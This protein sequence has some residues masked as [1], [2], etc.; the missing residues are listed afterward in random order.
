MSVIKYTTKPMAAIL[1]LTAGRHRDRREVG[2]VNGIMDG[3]MGLL[4]D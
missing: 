4:M 2:T 1:E 3:L